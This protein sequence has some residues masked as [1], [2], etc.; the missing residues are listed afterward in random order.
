MLP[1]INI[2]ENIYAK[3]FNL[4][5]VELY[6]NNSSLIFRRKINQVFIW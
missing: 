5:N 2:I 3:K 6:V 1:S 4:K